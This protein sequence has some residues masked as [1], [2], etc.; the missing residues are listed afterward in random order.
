MPDKGVLAKPTYISNVAFDD[1]RKAVGPRIP[2]LVQCS[3]LKLRIPCT[4][5]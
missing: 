1:K 5:G 2:L 4:E 3:H